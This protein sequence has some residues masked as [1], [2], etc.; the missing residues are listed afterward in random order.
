MRN[1]FLS[2]SFI[3]I[4]GLAGMI[5]QDGIAGVPGAARLVNQVNLSQ[6]QD[7]MFP[8]MR[9]V[10][11][12]H[13]PGVSEGK[14]AFIAEKRRKNEAFLELVKN[15]IHEASPRGAAVDPTQGINFKANPFSSGW[16]NDNDLAVNDQY[17]LSVTNSIIRVYDHN[18]S[19]LLGRSLEQFGGA[20]DT[21][22]GAF[23]PRALYDK[24]HD[25]WIVMYDNGGPGANPG[26]DEGYNN[27]MIAFSQT[28]DP[29]QGWNVYAFNGNLETNPNTNR[30]WMDY[31]QCAITNEELFV[32]GNMFRIIPD[33]NDP[34]NPANRADGIAIWQINLSDGYSGSGSI[35]FQV[36]R[37][38]NAFA[39][40]PVEG[41]PEI[42]GPEMYFLSKS[43]S[44]GRTILVYKI[45]GTMNNTNTRFTRDASLTAR[46]TYSTPPNARQPNSNND[47]D[48]LLSTN[49]GRVLHGFRSKQNLYGVFGSDVGGRPGIYLFRVQLSPLGSA[50]YG[51][52]TTTFSSPDVDFGFPSITFA[53]QTCDLP[54][55]N[56]VE[57]LFIGFNY[58][59]PTKFPGNG[60][61]YVNI[62]GE[63][64][65][66]VLLIE[67]RNNL[68]LTGLSGND[69]RNRWG[70][71]SD[72]A[73]RGNFWEAFIAGYYSEINGD[74]TTWISQVEV[75]PPQE[76][77]CSALS[78]DPAK[79]E[80]PVQELKAYPNPAFDYMTFE[81]K[82]E[83]RDMY[84]AIITDMQ[85]R[86]VK[87][88]RTD[89]LVP[90]VVKLGFNAAVLPAGQYQIV[91]DGRNAN[92]VLSKQFVVV[93]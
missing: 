32:T 65:D 33:P 89:V 60:V 29:T 93:K 7:D 41:E 51:L 5:A 91:V 88:V 19:Q 9:N 12:V 63:T 67:G 34:G 16:P 68:D 57:D 44:S 64:S 26:I 35:A 82:V 76:N 59:S 11:K 53:G 72:M 24:D 45:N 66:P 23:D 46:T 79:E 55:G 22:G 54:G 86:Q 58:S 18:G 43:S 30:L 6:V 2:F 17:I 70:D 36:Y 21:I 15:E 81:F 42:M 71:Y 25:R 69:P 20:N 56:S 31:P 50:F 37:D 47:P 83:E 10:S 73:N 90:G 74:H 48:R 3:V 1:I 40:T 38:V 39:L 49:D 80:A 52:E 8:V 78:I 87:H 84:R 75:N 77:W 62:N 85:G 4:A 92:R 28:G 13:F 61:Y 27:L 14:D